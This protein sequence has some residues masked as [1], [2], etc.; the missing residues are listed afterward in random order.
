M[1]GR[2]IGDK[3]GQQIQMIFLKFLQYK[4]FTAYVFVEAG[5]V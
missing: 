2:R 3:R 1:G 4:E 5:K